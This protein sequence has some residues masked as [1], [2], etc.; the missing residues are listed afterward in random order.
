MAVCGANG[1]ES[2]GYASD[3]GAPPSEGGE[4]P[5]EF[6]LGGGSDRSE[7]RAPGLATDSW[8]AEPRRGERITDLFVIREG[9]SEGGEAH[10]ELSRAGGG[11][12]TPDVQLGKLT[13]CP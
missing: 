8:R 11:N 9:A 2:T 12:R 6:F 5:S 13:F 4:A 7:P 10:S 3:S 1:E